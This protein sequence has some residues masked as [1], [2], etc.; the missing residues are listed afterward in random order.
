M[1]QITFFITPDGVLSVSWRVPEDELDLCGDAG[2]TGTSTDAED[3]PIQMEQFVSLGVCAVVLVLLYIVLRLGLL[4]INDPTVT[5]L[6]TTSAS[7]ETPAHVAIA[8]AV[9]AVGKV[10]GDEKPEL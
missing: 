3:P 9:D 4:D 6:S 10:I 7:D 2:A 1:L 8:A 5:T